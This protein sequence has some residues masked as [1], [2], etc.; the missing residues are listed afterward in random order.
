M[1]SVISK[2]SQMMYRMYEKFLGISDPKDDYPVRRDLE[3]A[4]ETITS[5][6]RDT[7]EKLNELALNAEEA[8]KDLTEK[9]AAR[10][11]EWRNSIKTFL[12]S[13]GI[14]PE[15]IDVFLAEPTVAK[16]EELRSSHPN[17]HNE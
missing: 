9:E 7:Y 13:A 3:K 8:L 5:N 1:N 2:M 15:S 12:E 16:I 6:Q 14:D 10:N 11:R 17:K 4:I